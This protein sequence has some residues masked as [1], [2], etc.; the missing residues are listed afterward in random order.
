MEGDNDRSVF[1]LFK[2]LRPF[3]PRDSSRIEESVTGVVCYDM[4]IS[5][6]GSLAGLTK[7]STGLSE[8]TELSGGDSDDSALRRV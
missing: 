7:P 1:A 3:Y 4:L 2:W 6:N 5:S 8:M